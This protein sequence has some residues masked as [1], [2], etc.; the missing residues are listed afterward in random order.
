MHMAITMACM[1]HESG[2]DIEFRTLSGLGFR[3]PDPKDV[4]LRVVKGLR[5]LGFRVEVRIL[6]APKALAVHP[7]PWRVRACAH[8]EGEALM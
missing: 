2:V 1:D 8:G 3:L 4:D 5:A 6:S 7:R